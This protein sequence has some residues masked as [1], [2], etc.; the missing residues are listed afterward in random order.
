MKITEKV[1][2]KLERLEGELATARDLIREAINSWPN[3][4]TLKNFKIHIMFHKETFTEK[5]MLF[6]GVTC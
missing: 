4:T 6:T 5:P 1:D 2:R 3:L